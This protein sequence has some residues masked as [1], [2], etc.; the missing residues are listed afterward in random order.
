MGHWVIDGLECDPLEWWGE[1]ASWW[2]SLEFR[3][4]LRRGSNECNTNSGSEWDEEDYSLVSE[5]GLGPISW[6]V[7]SYAGSRQWTGEQTNV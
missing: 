7:D 3:A 4:C 6:V 2:G 1:L 5:L